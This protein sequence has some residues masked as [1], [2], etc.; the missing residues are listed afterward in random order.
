[1]GKLPTSRDLTRITA[2]TLLLLLLAA[3]CGTEADVDTNAASTADDAHP[4]D[5]QAILSFL[6]GPEATEATLRQ[7]VRI[8]S[9]AA[10]SV[11]RHVRGA[12]SLLCT[13]DDD[14]LQS[15]AELDAIRNVGPVTISTIDAWL[16]ARGY[17]PS[18][19]VEGVPFTVDEARGIVAARPIQLLAA[20]S[21]V[22]A[23]ALQRIRNPRRGR[24]AQLPDRLH[25]RRRRYHRLRQRRRVLERR[26]RHARLD[27]RRVPRQQPGAGRLPRLAQPAADRGRPRR[28]VAARRRARAAPRR[29]HP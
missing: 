25:H 27:A 23:T 1:M 19:E 24:R 8:K 28:S 13:A 14:L 6:N 9:I 22:S 17:Q 7:E 12:D 10:S 21:Y 2:A 18:F 3:A 29:A 26:G 15:I 11:V 5:A 4:L 20:V 16:R